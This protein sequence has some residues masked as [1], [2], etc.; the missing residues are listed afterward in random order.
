MKRTSLLLAM[1]LGLFV[2]LTVAAGISYAMSPA[3][4]A[5]IRKIDG[6]RYAY[7]I[8]PS[9]NPQGGTETIDVSSN[10][11]I[12]G[13]I[14]TDYGRSYYHES[15]R[16]DIQGRVTRHQWQPQP[17]RKVWLMYAT[18]TI[19]DDGEIIT[20]REHWSDGDVRDNVYF[21]QR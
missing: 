6:R 21:W 11:F 9:E 14:N 3:D 18:Y 17:G 12:M 7:F 2:S 4:E 16:I 19:S 15:V 20:E 8:P 10:T 13:I 5:L 1:V